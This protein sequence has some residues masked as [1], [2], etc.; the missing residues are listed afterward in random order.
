MNTSLLKR[1]AVA[2]GGAALLLGA[3]LGYSQAQTATPSAA[4]QRHQAVIDLAAAKLGLTSDQLAAALKAART[5][6]GV[7]QGGVQVG[8]LVHQQLSVAAT[9]LGIADVKTLRKELAGTTLTAVAR[10]HNVDP[11]TVAAALKADVD[12]RIQALVTAGTLKPARAATLKVKA[13]ARVDA[14][15]THEFKPAKPAG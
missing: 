7:N 2:V 6:L 12:A 5:D 15:M 11:S 10:K 9:T 1:S 14:F 13:E 3:T 8:K 4:V